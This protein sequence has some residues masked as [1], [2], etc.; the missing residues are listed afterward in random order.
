MMEQKRYMSRR[1]Q[2]RDV[3]R[4]E[5]LRVPEVGRR[6]EHASAPAGNKT[7]HHSQSKDASNPY[8]ETS[9]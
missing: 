9:D 6:E 5:N 1:K 8:S 2:K 7:T 3:H 4:I